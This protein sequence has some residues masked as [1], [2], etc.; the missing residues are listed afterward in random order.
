VF[1]GWGSKP[2]FSEYSPQGKQLSNGSFRSPV[3][4][5]RANRSTWVGKPLQPPAI[6]VTASS[7]AGEDLVYASWNGATQV[8]DWQVLSSSTSTG[9]FAPAGPPA[10]W[11]GF[12][13]KVQ[14]P[15]DSASYFEVEAL[16]STGSVL[17]TSAAVAGP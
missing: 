3:A 17:G 8:A 6:A 5:Y 9:P 15:N 4:S 16:S 1:V 7:T 2:Y 12:E 13:T 14:V 11:S 10:P